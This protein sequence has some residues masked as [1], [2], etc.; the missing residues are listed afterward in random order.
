M[1][2]VILMGRITKDVEL[3]YS[4]DGKTAIGYFTI[5]VDRRFKA[6]GEQRK[7]DFI[8][9][10]SFSKTAEFINSHFAKGDG[11]GLICEVQTD[12]YDN[13]EGKKVYTTDI[14]VDEA[15]FLPSKVI[16]GDA[17]EP[18]G[19]DNSFYIPTGDGGLPF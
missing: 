5:A 13:A 14:V 17:A 15:Y 16:R 6:Q 10:K 19:A 4:K 18:K 8:R 3:R 1:N 9:C 7:T 2:K 12:S 11:I